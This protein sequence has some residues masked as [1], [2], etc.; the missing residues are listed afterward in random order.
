[1]QKYISNSDTQTQEIAAKLAKETKNH[2]FALNGELGAGKTVFVQGFAKALEIKDKIISP[3]FVLMRQHQIPNTKKVL[4]HIDLYRLENITDIGQLGLEEIWSNPNN[5]ILIEWA[6]KI[7]KL[8][9]GTIK[10]FIHKEGLN[11]RKIL[12]FNV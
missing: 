4:Y 8:P 6:E 3:T 12:V 5:V 2:I 11:K 1:M 7:N 9:K 10:I